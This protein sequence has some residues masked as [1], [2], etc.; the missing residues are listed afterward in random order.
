MHVLK[1]FLPLLALGTLT[2]STSLTQADDSS[3]KPGL[4]EH[5]IQFTS[6]S[7]E[8]EQM[9]SQ[10]RQQLEALPPE[11][12]GMLENMMKA[13]GVDFDFQSQTF[14]TCLSP[15]KAAEGSLAL[16][17][18]NDCEETG[19]STS[20]GSTTI[21]FACSG[22]TQADGTVTFDGDTLYTGQ[23]NATVDLQGRPQKMSVNH[24]G[25]WQGNDC[26]DIQP[27]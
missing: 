18:D 22:Q 5:K 3:M 17:K 25:E 19:R 27:Q 11:Q 16:M 15:E 14:K 13:Q 7:G 12:R 10:L 1:R 8:L 4:W 6:E 23:S 9:M 20:G 2:L 26:G 24:Q 21:T